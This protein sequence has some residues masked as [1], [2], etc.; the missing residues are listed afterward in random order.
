MCGRAGS[1]DLDDASKFLDTVVRNVPNRARLASSRAHSASF[2]RPCGPGG[3][4]PIEL[5][6]PQTTWVQGLTRQ[7]SRQD[8][9]RTPEGGR[10]CR[11]DGYLGAVLRP[12]RL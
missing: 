11:N 3:Q 7:K 2:L 9:R 12:R 6:C 1:H 8:G 4:R 5:S 10:F